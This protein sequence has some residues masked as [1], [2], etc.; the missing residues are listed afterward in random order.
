MNNIDWQ[1][2]EGGRFVHYVFAL[3]FGHKVIF[4]VCQQYELNI[5]NSTDDCLFQNVPGSR[6]SPIHS[7]DS[8]LHMCDY[9]W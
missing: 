8:K 7:V 2:G 9:D 6:G 1:G 3:V 4:Y 5:Q